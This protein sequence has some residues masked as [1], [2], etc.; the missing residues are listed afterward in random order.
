ML[1]EYNSYPLIV[2]LLQCWWLWEQLVDWAAAAD[3]VWL[4]V[5]VE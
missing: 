4:A 5:V 2:D 1:L 3:P